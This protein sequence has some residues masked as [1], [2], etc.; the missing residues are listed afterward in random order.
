MILPK[1]SNSFHIATKLKHKHICGEKLIVRIISSCEDN[2]KSNT[3]Q[4][5]RMASL[6]LVSHQ[7]IGYLPPDKEN[8]ICCHGAACYMNA[9]A[10]RC[11]YW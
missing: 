7:N 1:R 5:N 4:G 3:L 6:P 2:L 10:E 11:N 8:K 9:I